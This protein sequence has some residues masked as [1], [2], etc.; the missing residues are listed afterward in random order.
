MKKFFYMLLLAVV[1]MTTA[2]TIE[3]DDLFSESSA[4]RADE[5]M[6]AN[7][8]IL[9]SAS[10]GW[11]MA[12]FPSATKA[13][14]GYNVL[15]KFNKD[16]SVEAS[17]E[18]YD[19]DFVASSS[20]TIKQSAGIVL[21]MDTYNEA[22]HIFSDPSDPTGWGG[23]GE[24]LGGDYDFLIVEATAEKVV[25]KGKKTG[26]ISV[27][28]PMAEGESW[29]NY[30]ADIQARDAS[31]SAKKMKMVLGGTEV[32]VKVDMRNLIFSYLQGEEVEQIRVP[33]VVNKEGYVFYEPVEILGE[34]LE[35]FT[36]NEQK[37]EF[38]S[39]GSAEVI[40]QILPPDINEIFSKGLWYISY[41][42]LGEYAQRYYNA[43]NTNIWKPNKLNLDMACFGTLGQGVFG[44]G[45]QVN[46]EMGILLFDF[47][48]QGSDKVM[49][50]MNGNANQV[51]VTFFSNFGF[52]Y[53]VHPFGD[54]STP[55]MF[56]VSTDNPK[57][58]TY[59]R[60]TDVNEPTNVIELSAMPVKN[61]MDK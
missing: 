7:M 59:M 37:D 33:F 22:F 25:L 12:Y 13:F 57:D 50:Q 2:C 58:P 14:G 39:F 49:M 32:L 26:G 29:E 53:A 28:T 17:S 54:L 19:A 40:V 27:M 21:S 10:N 56:T 41:S 43:A 61:P 24:G 42:K 8:D 51:G 38:T 1:S 52:N 5:A 9:T 48:L 6:K 36:F 18:F 45:F 47:V 4:I 30:L 46:N 11:K 44:F 31:I 15:I 34:K 16:R 35:G 23:A 20:Y 55:R 60:L 3:Q